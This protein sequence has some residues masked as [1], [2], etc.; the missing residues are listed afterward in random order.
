M[1]IN[2][3]LIRIY[4]AAGDICNGT[5]RYK[6]ELTIKAEPEQF[7]YDVDQ[8]YDYNYVSNNYNQIIRKEDCLYLI[9]ITDRI[10][11]IYNNYY[12]LNLT[13]PWQ[14]V[15]GLIITILG[16]VIKILNRRSNNIACYFTLVVGLFFP[17]SIIVD[18]FR[19]LIHLLAFGVF[20]SFFFYMIN[21]AI[22]RSCEEIKRDSKRYNIVLGIL[23]GYPMIKMISIFT[24]AFIKTTYQRLIHNIFLLVFS[25][26]GEL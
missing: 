2:D 19:F 5:E 15:F 13:L 1:V 26:S 18:L 17:M 22:L 25:I 24:I 21:A 20:A 14:I 10:V 16:L 6:V 8:Y 12:G 11:T 7:D 9:N 4:L 23:C 3:T